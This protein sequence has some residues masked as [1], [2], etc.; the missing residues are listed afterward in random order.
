LIG[1]QVLAALFAQ[2]AIAASPV[3]P[4]YANAIADLKFSDSI[5]FF[6][7]ETY[8]LMPGNQRAFDDSEQMRPIALGYMKIGMTDSAGLDFD[9][10]FVGVRLRNFRVFE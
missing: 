1:A 2:L 10:N 4:R 8:H 7:H 5:T 6:D 3:G 9:Q